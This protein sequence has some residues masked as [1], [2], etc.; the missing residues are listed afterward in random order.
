[1]ATSHSQKQL[2]IPGRVIFTEGN[3]ELPKIQI[4]T[5]WS[6]AEIYLHGAHITHFQK[7]DE[8]PILFLSQLS[9]F[10]EG[11]PIRG[12]IPVIFPWFGPRE[13]EPA[14]GFARVQNWE[15]REIS[16]LA[17]GGVKLRLSLPDSPDAALLPKFTAD[18]WVTVGKTLSAELIVTNSSTDQD[19][20]FEN[21]LHS[22]FVVGD[23]N[24][25]S[26]TG[27]KGAEFLDK[28]ENFARKTER[29]EHIKISSETDRIYLDTTSTTEI[30]DSKL[31][32]RIRV[33]KSGSLSTIVWNPWTTKAQQMPDFGNEE[34][35]QM[36]C[37]ESGNVSENKVTLP[38]GKSASLKIEL[39]TLAL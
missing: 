10:Q 13:G 26:V 31:Q 1:M 17:D 15:L 39:S 3:G 36:V 30:H 8:P 6:T 16:Q 5:A 21:C 20:T 34:F 28:T 24:S 35:Q 19:F 38:A 18:F 25:I 4:T 32:R 14:H 12:G 2:E 22:Y 37:V 27:L 7:K 33:E 9:R 29:A 11:T 23:V